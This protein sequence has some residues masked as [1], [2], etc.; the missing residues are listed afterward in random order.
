MTM[1]WGWNEG[2]MTMEWGWNGGGMTMEW[3]WNPPSFHGIHT[4]FYGIHP[5]HLH[6]IW[7]NLGRVK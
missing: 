7:K 5:F 4:L 6:S 1:E 3:R 2:G